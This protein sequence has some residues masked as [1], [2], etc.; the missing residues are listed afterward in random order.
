LIFPQ[1]TSFLPRNCGVFFER[2]KYFCELLGYKVVVAEIKQVA[3]E[4]VAKGLLEWQM[5]NSDLE[6]QPATNSL[7][8]SFEIYSLATNLSNWQRELNQFE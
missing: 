5:S 8:T 6:T 7:A 1:N 2:T 3:S 4:W